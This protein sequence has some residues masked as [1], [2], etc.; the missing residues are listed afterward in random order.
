MAHA[1]GRRAIG[2]AYELLLAL[3][4]G[5][6]GLLREIQAKFHLNKQGFAQRRRER[7]EKN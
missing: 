7:R 5:D 3:L 4:V 1:E 6:V 2:R